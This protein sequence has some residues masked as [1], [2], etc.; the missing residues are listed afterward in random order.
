MILALLLLFVFL[1]TAD[2]YTTHKLLSNGGT[3]L[4]P[5]MRWLMNQLG[6]LQALI[7]MKLITVGLVISLFN[8][9]L[10][11]WLCMMYICVVGWNTY[12]LLKD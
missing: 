4:N 2:V 3:E 1:Q 11:F 7:L 10:T 9:T 12:N 5:F 6:I 8:E